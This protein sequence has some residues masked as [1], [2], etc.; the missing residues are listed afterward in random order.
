MCQVEQGSVLWLCPPSPCPSMELKET[1]RGQAVPEVQC[2]LSLGCE[3]RRGSDRFLQT[4]EALAMCHFF[5]DP[6][7]VLVVCFGGRFRSEALKNNFPDGFPKELVGYMF[8]RWCFISVLLRVEVDG[9]ERVVVVLAHGRNLWPSWCRGNIPRS[10][11]PA[12]CMAHFL[13]QTLLLPCAHPP[14][15]SAL[16][17]FMFRELCFQWKDLIVFLVHFKKPRRNTQFLK[18]AESESVRMMARLPYP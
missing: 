12:W 4:T 15:V 2:C 10:I 16:A 7:R 18:Q 5:A 13:T 17:P 9:V 14:T 11:R 1:R 8:R 3:A 6:A